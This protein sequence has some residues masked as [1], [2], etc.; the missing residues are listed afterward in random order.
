MIRIA[1]LAA[2][3]VMLGTGAASAQPGWYGYGYGEGYGYGGGYPYRARP[4]YA[5]MPRHRVFSVVRAVGLRPVSEAMRVGP[6][7]IV[8]AID[9]SGRLKRV[10]INA[11]YGQVVRITAVTRPDYP[12]RSAA[13]VARHGAVPDD[14]DAREEYGPPPRRAARPAPPPAQ[15]RLPD[16]EEAPLPSA[17]GDRDMPAGREIPPPPAPLNMHKAAKPVPPKPEKKAVRGH[18]EPAAA[19]DEK[20]Q[21]DGE[22]RAAVNPHP[23]VKP[24]SHHMPAE[25]PAAEKPAEKKPAAKPE[26]QAAVPRVVL[27]GGPSLKSGP[28]PKSEPAHAP[29][30]A[31]PAPPATPAPGSAELPPVQPLN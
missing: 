28:A 13:P 8:D 30:A 25:K 14:A 1:V 31:P 4:Y 3:T 27:P 15:A 26:A 5:A 29:Q 19:K 6:N 21:K 2:A 7:F 12:P 17:A 9:S 20:T 18:E 11:Y 22:R 23:T 16:N 24:E 10:T